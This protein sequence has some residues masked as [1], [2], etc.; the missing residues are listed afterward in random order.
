MA[1]D[2]A[3]SQR[4]VTFRRLVPSDSLGELTDLLHRAY[5][6][7]AAAGFR[8][9]ASWQDELVTRKRCE[10]A[11]CWVAVLD[12][13]IIGTGTL[14]SPGRSAG[15]PWYEQAGVAVIEQFAVEPAHQRVGLGTTLLRHLEERA[16]Q[17]GAI[18]VA[19]DTAEGPSHLVRYYERLGYVFVEYVQWNLANYRSVILSKSLHRD[20]AAGI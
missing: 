1:E 15:T 13:R 18:H 12:G 4:V 16:R 3:A 2:L 17:V 6:P 19:L 10:S 9:W 7:H 20:P 11:E 5:A 8:F 14:L